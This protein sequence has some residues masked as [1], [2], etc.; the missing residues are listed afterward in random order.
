MSEME[1]RICMDQSFSDTATLVSELEFYD[2][3]LEN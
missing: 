1:V 2:V 3:G